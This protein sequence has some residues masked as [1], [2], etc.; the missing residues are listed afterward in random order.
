MK[1]DNKALGLAC[2]LLWGGGV[3]LATLW[4]SLR[5]GGDHLKL[6]SQFYVGY[7]VSVTGAFL[8]LLYGFVDGFLGGWILAWLYNRFAAPAAS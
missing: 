8:G 2:G 6:L 3:F 1:L 5:G 4:I 7:G